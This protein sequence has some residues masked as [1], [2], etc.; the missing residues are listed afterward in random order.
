MSKQICAVVQSSSTS[1]TAGAT[2]SGS[3]ATGSVA[4]P[5]AQSTSPSVATNAAAAGQ[6]GLSWIGA[7]AVVGAL[8]L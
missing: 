5:T 6:V 8:A 7:A 4:S 1:G 2:G 3:A